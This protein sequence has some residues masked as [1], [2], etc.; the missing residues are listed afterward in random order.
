MTQHTILASLRLQANLLKQIALHTCQKWSM[1]LL[2]LSIG[3]D[4]KYRDLTRLL[5]NMG[6]DADK[7]TI[8][9][10]FKRLPNLKDKIYRPIDLTERK[11][12]EIIKP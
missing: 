9:C 12:K 7:T 8:S 6:S 11:M 1:T 3:S 10:R 5:I 4:P 2:V